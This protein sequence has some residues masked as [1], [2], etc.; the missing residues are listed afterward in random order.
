MIKRKKSISL[1]ILALS[2]ISLSGCSS[3]TSGSEGVILTYTYNGKESQINTS[4]IIDKYLSQ[5]RNNHA[6]AFFNALNEVV[7]RRAFEKGGKLSSFKT[8]VENA[9]T[10]DVEKQ[11]IEC[12][13]K[14]QSWEDYLDENI[15][16]DDLTTEEKEEE[17]FLQKEYEQMQDTVEDQYF[18]TFNS[19]QKDSTDTTADSEQ[20]KYNLLY[21]ENGYIQNKV[22]YH[23]RHIL[24]QVDAS[25]DYGYSRGHI[26]S[27][28]AHQIYQVVTALKNGNS[29]ADTANLYTDDDTGNTG[30]NGNKLGGEYIMDN[31]E[32]FVN[33]F[34]LG[35]YTYDLL[36]ND[37]NIAKYEQ[38]GKIYNIKR[39]NLH[40]PESAE[41][42][43]SNFGVTYIPYEV[44]D[45]L[46]RVK[47]VTTYNGVSIN[48]GDEDYFPRN[49]YFN[50]YFQNRNVAFITNEALLTE[51]NLVGEENR[52]DYT[53][54]D[55]THNAMLTRQDNVSGN[56][57]YSDID[58]SGHYKTSNVPYFTNEE[59]D[60]PN[61]QTITINGEPKNVLCDT[62]DNPILVVRNQESSSGIHFIV[63]ERSAFDTEGEENSPKASI[64]EYYAPVSPKSDDGIDPNTGRPYWLTDGTFPTYTVNING[65]DVTLP[66]QTYVQT[67][68]I[69][70]DSDVN[71]TVSNYTTR[72]SK[73]STD[74][75]TAINTYDTFDWLNTDDITLENMGESTSVQDMVDRYIEKEKRASKDSTAQTLEDSWMA[76]ASSILEQ[77]RQ[78]EY[79]LLPEILAQDFGNSAL[80][81]QGAPGYNPAY[82]GI[83]SGT[84]SSTG[85]SSSN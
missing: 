60:T 25:E 68:E 48:D 75:R 21:G 73:L 3:V 50:K 23:I 56:T 54:Y 39:G 78:R 76:Y 27:D 26:S 62:N 57:I 66:K 83:S 70:P 14:G 11:K 63:I 38:D 33:E 40:I 36:L 5:D 12:D 44:I 6:A 46:E 82:D 19:Y 41:T 79:M 32:S 30:D 55:P 18:E 20:D 67:A 49:I 15:P 80:Y 34:K 35:V 4:D 16:G 9:A 45:E 22:P 43:L 81:V 13:K 71:D 47:D 69:S 28:D 85:N 1:A 59:D 64:E 42:T 24:V 37:E 58:E 10:D 31:E 72:V 74:I 29:F 2:A 51:Q 53:N 77:A 8:T 84:T 7:I 17:F 61:F 65:T 52:K